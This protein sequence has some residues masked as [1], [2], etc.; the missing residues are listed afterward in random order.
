M[1]A[2]W[3][4]SEVVRCGVC[5]FLAVT[6]RRSKKPVPLFLRVPLILGSSLGG[7]GRHG[8]LVTGWS[9]AMGPLA[10]TPYKH[11]N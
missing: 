9:I 10:L 7:G 2:F 3:P 5:V 8:Q 4:F 11:H 6:W 1:V